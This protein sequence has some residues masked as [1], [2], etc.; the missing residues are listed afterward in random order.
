MPGEVH[1]DP[2]IL[3]RQSIFL[4]YASADR[5]AARAL[6]D[7]LEI[8]GLDVWLDEDELGG[9]EAWDAKIRN[10]IRTCTYFMPIISATTEVRGEGYFRREWR[11]AVERTLDLADDILF[12]VPVVIDDT[13]D[14]GARVPEKFFSVQWLRAPGGKSSAGLTEL[15]K[16]LAVGE[17]VAIAPVAAVPVPAADRSRR[18]NRAAT[19]AP[20]PFPAFPAFPEPGHRLRFCYNLLLWGGHVLLSLWGHLPRFFRVI[21]SIFIIFNLITWAFRESKS[22]RQGGEGKAVPAGA[23]APEV[24][25]GRHAVTPGE[26]ATAAVAIEAAIGAAAEALQAGRPLAVIKFSSEGDHAG[27]LSDDVFNQLMKSLNE[28]DNLEASISPVPLKADATDAEIIDRGNRLKSQFV[29]SG[30]SRAATADRAPGFT[31]KLYDVKLAKLIWTETYDA[32]P[33]DAAAITRQ[34][35]IELEKRT[36]SAKA[37]E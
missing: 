3:P 27:T 16:K 5:A 17:A 32:P 34:L 35:S 18:K 4:S 11:L 24:V 8:A 21:A 12:L 22:A 7:T 20:P 28:E 25:L 14:A 30:F 33:N 2:P 19:E 29:L 10:Q 6:R 9:G 37:A 13:R 1:R 26:K 36:A 15:A 23:A 31:A